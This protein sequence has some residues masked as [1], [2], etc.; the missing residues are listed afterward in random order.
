[1]HPRSQLILIV[2]ALAL[3]LQSYAQKPPT[4]GGNPRYTVKV[5]MLNNKPV[6][7]WNFLY[8]YDWTQKVERYEHE[9]P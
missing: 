8:Y 3:I 4:W 5:K 9:S 6:V 2:L 1:M 7:T